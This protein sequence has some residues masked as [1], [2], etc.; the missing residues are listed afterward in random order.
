MRLHFPSTQVSLPFWAR[1]LEKRRESA[2]CFR[3]LS[4]TLPCPCLVISVSPRFRGVRHLRVVV[5]G[6]P[7]C[8]FLGETFRKVRAGYALRFSQI[9]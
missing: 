9:V 8:A 4:T 6:N 3:F 7:Y 5:S 2:P 1:P